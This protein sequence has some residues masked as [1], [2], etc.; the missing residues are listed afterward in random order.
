MID[1]IKTHKGLAFSLAGTTVLILVLSY[2]TVVKQSDVSD[3][4]M[5]VEEQTDRLTQ[6]FEKE[7][8]VN[9][10]GLELAKKNRA[11]VAKEYGAVVKELSVYSIPI[12]KMTATRFKAKLQ[13]KLIAINSKVEGAGIVVNR[14]K[15]PSFSVKD[16]TDKQESAY[17]DIDFTKGSQKIAIIESL[18]DVL[19][20]AKISKIDFLSWHGSEDQDEAGASFVSSL[21]FELTIEGTQ[22]SIKDTVS[23]LSSDQRILF[24]IK[25]LEINNSTVLAKPSVNKSKAVDFTSKESREIKVEN[26][27]TSKLYVKVLQFNIAESK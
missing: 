25:S 4:K 12:I 2:L 16:L 19:V 23:G 18:A 17:V 21:E 27:L 10:E 1:L 6:I 20:N 8:S 11:T 13:D 15:M 3:D 7:F 24:F 22:E 5:L 14:T 26:Q 9:D